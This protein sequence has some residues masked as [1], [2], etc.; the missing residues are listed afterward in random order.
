MTQVAEMEQRTVEIVQPPL[1]HFN[2]IAILGYTEHRNQAPYTAPGSEQ[3]ALWGLNDLYIDIPEV[4]NERVRWFQLHTWMEVTKWAKVPATSRPLELNGGPPHPRD[5]NHTAWLTTYS[6]HIP[7]FVRRKVEEMPLAYEF[8]FQAV[9]E[10]FARRFPVTQGKNIYF[11]NTISYMIGLAIMELIDPAT[12]RAYPEAELGVWGVDMMMAGGAG[13]EYGYQR[14]SIEY[15]LGFAQGA[16]ITIHLPLETD[17][18]KTAYPYGDEV[19]EAYRARLESHRKDL[20]KR[21]AEVENAANQYQGA[22]IELGGAINALEWTLRSHMPGDSE[23][24][25]NVPPTALAPKPNSHKLRADRLNRIKV[26]G[27]ENVVT[28]ESDGKEE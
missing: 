20:A 14:P 19:G 10:W 4:P 7:I 8:P 27:M 2:K 17:L 25:G 22:A 11:T 1:R 21:K 16:G 5:P 6:Q 24:A 15:L 12:D 3:W 13:S 28:P 23:F 9:F 18:L 26:S